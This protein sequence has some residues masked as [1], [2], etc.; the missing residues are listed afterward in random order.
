MLYSRIGSGLEFLDISVGGLYANRS[1]LL[2]GP[3]ESG[4]TTAVLQYLIAGMENGENTVMISSDR[5]ENVIVKADRIGIS[6]EPYLTSNRLVLMEYPPEIVTGQFKYASTIQLLGDIEKVVKLYRSTRLALDTLQPLLGKQEE[7]VLVNYIY[8]LVNAFDEMNTTVLFTVGDPTAPLALR[9]IQLLEDAVVGSFSLAKVQ[10]KDGFSRAFSIHKLVNR[11]TPPTTF[12]VHFEYGLGLIQ[13]TP[14]DSGDSSS[15]STSS[16]VHSLQAVPIHTYLLDGHKDTVNQIRRI[17]HS[18]SRITAFDSEE[19]FA[20]NLYNFDCDLLMINVNEASFN[21]QQI[22]AL[23]RD[24]YPK[25]PIFLL[26]LEK[27]T[28]INFQ[29]ARRSGADGLFYL[30]LASEEV[31]KAFEKTVRGYGTLEQ[32]LTKTVSGNSLTTKDG[33]ETLGTTS[34]PGVDVGLN[35]EANLLQLPKFKELLTRQIW[36]ASRANTALALISFKLVILNQPGQQDKLPQ[37]MELIKRAGA[38]ITGALRGANDVACRNMDK[39]V[40]QLENCNKAGAN[41]YTQRAINDIKDNIS[42]TLGLQYNRHFY[43]LFAV[44]VFPEDGDN[45]N[46]LLYQVTDVSKNFIKSIR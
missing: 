42:T 33:S 23:A 29:Q 5:I 6:L 43:I 17:F 36:S 20:V 39:I 45:G 44:A 19:E 16:S 37:G 25:L 9:I 34:L 38:V 26:A 3:S 11:I 24:Y 46:D 41:A 22:V 8:S 18:D 21:W 12:R 31:L 7:P 14:A 4:R 10:S 30:P 32:L 2:R 13:D 35:T 40:V 28:A 27:D 15:A 1:Y